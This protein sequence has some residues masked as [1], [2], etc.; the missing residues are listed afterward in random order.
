MMV[1]SGEGFLGG[2]A[3]KESVS[4][5]G[6]LGLITGLGRSPGEGNDYLLFYHSLAP[7]KY[8]GGNTAPPTHFFNPHKIGLKVYRTW[9]CPSE[10]DPISPQSVSPIRKLP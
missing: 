10:Q 6:D 8:Q 9:P 1:I 4:N 7:G 2:S 3:G 5:A